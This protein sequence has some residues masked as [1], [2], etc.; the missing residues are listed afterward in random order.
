MLNH[1]CYSA[2]PFFLHCS[3][4]LYFF[5]TVISVI[6][7]S[8][9]P[10]STLS[11]NPAIF[12]YSAQSFYEV[13]THSTTVNSTICYSALSHCCYSSQLFCDFTILFSTV[14]S[15]NFATVFNHF[16]NFIGHS[17]DFVSHF[18]T[19]HSTILE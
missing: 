9:Q 15:T 3:V 8:C 1:S 18:A 19:M 16:Y 5:V 13:V 10:F 4:I 17:R 11:V 14:N 6:F 12:C 7:L 2:Q